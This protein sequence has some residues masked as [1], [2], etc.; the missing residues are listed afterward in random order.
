M[1]IPQE[2]LRAITVPADPVPIFFPSVEDFDGDET[3]Y[4]ATVPAQ[5]DFVT[6][7]QLPDT[8]ALR[9]TEDCGNRVTT[10]F[11][12]PNK[13]GEYSGEVQN[14][15]MPLKGTIAFSVPL[16]VLSIVSDG[17]NTVTVTCSKV[18]NLQLNADATGLPP[19]ISVDDLTN[20]S[21]TG[22]YTATILTATA[23]TYNTYGPIIPAG[24]LLTPNTRLVTVSLG[25]PRGFDEIPKIFGPGFLIPTPNNFNIL[26]EN[27]TFFL[28]LEDGT[29]F[30]L[31]IG[32]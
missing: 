6:G 11:G 4:R 18:H 25:L 14:A 32:P 10:P 31:E 27:G 17:A 29:F 28:L 22:F 21:A 3:D 7:I 26:L 1:D 19:Q 8:Q 20:R 2:Q 16:P 30:E 15:V 13:H 23:F 12:V 24:S 5:F 9:T